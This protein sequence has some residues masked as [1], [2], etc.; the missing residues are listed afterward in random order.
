M[1]KVNPKILY[2]SVALP[3]PYSSAAN[4]V[5]AFRKPMSAYVRYRTKLEQ[6]EYSPNSSTLDDSFGTTINIDK[7][8]V[9]N[10]MNLQ[11]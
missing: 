11:K 1:Q 3:F 6:K 9:I 4:L 10:E 8:P 5:D 7:N 2:S